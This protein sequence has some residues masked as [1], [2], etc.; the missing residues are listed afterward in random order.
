MC[1]F[2]WYCIFMDMTL[3]MLICGPCL[4]ILACDPYMFCFYNRLI[5]NIDFILQE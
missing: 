2:F 1:S 5:V 3:G 4:M